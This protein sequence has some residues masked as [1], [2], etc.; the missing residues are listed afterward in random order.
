MGELQT[1]FSI[2]LLG[3]AHIWGEGQ[4]DPLLKIC[5]TYP[6]MMKIGLF[7]PYRKKIQKNI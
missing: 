1:I 6:T 3:A 5:H 7:V 4:K 2:G